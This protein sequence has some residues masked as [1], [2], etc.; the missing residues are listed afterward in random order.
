[1]WSKKIEGLEK[2]M[3]KFNKVFESTYYL[4]AIEISSALCISDLKIIF[5]LYIRRLV[6]IGMRRHS[7]GP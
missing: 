3:R 5:F 4:F 6:F 1:M 7:L 2:G